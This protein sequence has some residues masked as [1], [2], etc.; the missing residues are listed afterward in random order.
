MS[1]TLYGIGL[2]PGDAE[3][4][5]L[6]AAQLIGAA[7]VVAYPALAGGESFARSIA[8]ELLADG[9]QEIRIDVPMVVDRAPAQAAY[10]KAADEISAALETG[11]D[12]VV[13]CEGDPFFYGSFMYLYARLSGRFTVEVVPGVTSI[14]ASA[15]A[16]G[17]PLAARNEV[18]SVIPGPLEDEALKV[19]IAAADSVVIMKVGRHLERVRRVIEGLDLL[20][21]AHY[22]ERA[23]LEQER[24]MA[25]ADAPQKAPYFSMI[26]ITKGA[27]PWL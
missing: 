8:A 26:L 13:L 3:L 18:L 9:V 17:L 23:S 5:T 4:M 11:L 15:A 16:L 20:D 19:L 1:G 14:T 21:R 27:D 10:D 25:L 6:K 24:R 22:I 2:G 7:Q 12:V